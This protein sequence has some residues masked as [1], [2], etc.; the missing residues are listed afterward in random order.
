MTE[1]ADIPIEEVVTAGIAAALLDLHT[2]LPGIVVRYDA[3]TGHADVQPAVKR[4]LARE[5]GS[6]A[7]ESLPT[8][9]NVRVCWPGAGGFE[10]RFPLGE[11]DTVWLMFA[12]ADTQRFEESGQESQ[13]GWLG[14]HALGSLVAYPYA[15]AAS[16]PDAGAR[17]VAPSPF[18]VGN[19]GAAQFVA[20]Q[21]QLT[22][23]KT[24]IDSAAATEAGASGLGG[25]SAL[26]AALGP[27]PAGTASTKLKAE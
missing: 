1:R 19:P 22:T 9:Q 14:R 23:L 17:L 2:A 15:R 25:M 20:L 27:W 13:P 24:A 7:Y 8:L 21:T 10:L 16:S 11:G 12:E 4:A 6:T 3:S 18:V 26:K 5:D